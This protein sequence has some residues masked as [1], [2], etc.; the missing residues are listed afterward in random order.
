MHT[1]P[2]ASIADTALTADTQPTAHAVPLADALPIK[3]I[4]TDVDGTILPYGQR[5]I[6][7]RTAKAMQAC[8]DAGIHIGPASG[9]AM[10][11]VEPAFGA[12]AY[13]CATGLATNGMQIYLDGELIYEAYLPYDQLAEVAAFCERH[14]D[15]GLGLILFE[16]SKIHLL[17][18]SIEGLAQSFPSYAERVDYIDS[19]PSYPVVKANVFCPVD[20][21]ITATALQEIKREVPGLDFSMPLAGFLNMTPKGWNKGTAIDVM[22]DK[23]GISLDEVCCFGDAGNDIEMLAHVKYSVA[24]ANATDE[25]K[26]VANFHIG[27]VEDEAVA[28]CLEQLAQGVIPFTGCAG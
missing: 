25:L 7:E 2:T 9:R 21:E 20:S 11:G 5:C 10:N 23:L 18:G 1:Q 15:E 4:L 16:D 22:C 13:L 26:E 6:S 24:V 19:L 3:L 28:A 17:S 8:M 14:T 27:S 12:Y